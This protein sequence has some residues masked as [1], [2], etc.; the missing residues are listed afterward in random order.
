MFGFNKKNNYN[1]DF[2]SEWDKTCKEFMDKQKPYLDWLAGEGGKRIYHLQNLIIHAYETA[3]I[4]IKDDLVGSRLNEFYTR[5]DCLRD[6]SVF[7]KPEVFKKLEY[8]CS[9]YETLREA[10]EKLIS[11]L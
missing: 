1:D 6:Y 10:E 9:E 7:F 3:N 11:E 4:N 5:A 8:W 2:Y